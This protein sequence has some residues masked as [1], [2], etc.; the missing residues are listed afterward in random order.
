MQTDITRNRP[1]ITLAGNGQA[2]AFDQDGSAYLLSKAPDDGRKGKPVQDRNDNL[3]GSRIQETY[4][5][6]KKWLETTPPLFRFRA[7][8]NCSSSCSIKIVVARGT[9]KRQSLS[10]FPAADFAGRKD[11]LA[12]TA[13]PIALFGV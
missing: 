13:E 2:D 8:G 12:A 10:D 9:V 4:A 3:A 6:P 7:E 1:R 5:S 11:G